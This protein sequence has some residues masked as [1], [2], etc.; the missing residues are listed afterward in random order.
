[1]TTQI[2]FLRAVNLGKRRVQMS[3]LV[4]IVDGLGYGDVWTHINS[5]NVVFTGSGSRDTMEKRLGTA[6]E[7][8]FG[9]EVTTFVRTAAELRKALDVDPFTVSSSDTYYLTFLKSSL[10]PA[11]RRALENLS[12]DFDTLVVKGRDVHWR[13][14]GPSTASKLKTKDWDVI[15]G[16]HCSTSRNVTMLRKLVEKIDR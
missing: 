15:V 4:E 6:F 16:R 11:K 12:N 1:M 14:H 2:A 5:G 7:K 9:F 13:M 3:R 10:S 8:A